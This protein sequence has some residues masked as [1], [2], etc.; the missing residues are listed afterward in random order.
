MSRAR[1]LRPRLQPWRSA[2]PLKQSGTP[3]DLTDDFNNMFY[4]VLSPDKKRTSI[5][6]IRD[7]SRVRLSGFRHA[8]RPTVFSETRCRMNF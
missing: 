4:V 1:R 8:G 5:T 3:A 6:R 2:T 7:H